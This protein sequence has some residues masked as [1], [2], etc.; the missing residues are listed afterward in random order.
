MDV[1]INTTFLASFYGVGMRPKLTAEWI[2]SNGST[3]P[4]RDGIPSRILYELCPGIYAETMASSSTVI[5][6]CH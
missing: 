1:R 5:L 6:F 4:P 2:G 3:C